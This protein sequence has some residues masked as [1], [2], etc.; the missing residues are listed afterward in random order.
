[1]S[2][3]VLNAPNLATE[4]IHIPGKCCLEVLPEVT[5]LRCILQPVPNKRIARTTS[6]GKENFPQNV[7]RWIAVNRDHIDVGEIHPRFGKTV[8]DRLYWK[9]CPMLEPEKSFFFG[10]S[11]YIPIH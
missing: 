7:R 4:N 6:Y 9:P 3:V 1:V 10:G 11:N 5:D 2:D 8:T